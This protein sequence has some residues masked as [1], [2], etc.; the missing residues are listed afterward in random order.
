MKSFSNLKQTTQK[1][2]TLIEVLIVVIVLGLISAIAVPAFNNSIE[3][4]AS[5]KLIESVSDNIADATR[6]LLVTTGVVANVTGSVIPDTENDQNLLD[7]LVKG[8]DSVAQKYKNDFEDAS[9]TKLDRQIGTEL[10]NDGNPYYA[11]NGYAVTYTS[12]SAGI[13][14]VQFAGVPAEIAERIQES[15]E[16][17][18]YNSAADTS[19]AVRTTA[20]VDG[21]TDLT[22][23][24]DL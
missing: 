18:Q 16:G 11:V 7:V 17:T 24:F 9:I 1:G 5:V 15:R 23:A 10:D 2:F 8:I 3:R 20:E 22:L 6:S 14:L 12:D 19:G 4:A 21:L 13:G